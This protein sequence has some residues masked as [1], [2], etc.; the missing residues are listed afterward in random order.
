M[1]KKKSNMIVCVHGIGYDVFA[2]LKWQQFLRIFSLLVLVL[3]AVVLGM[4]LAGRLP[5]EL[6]LTAVLVLILAVLAVLAL[7]RSAIRREYRQS[8]LGKL[9][10]QYEFDR[11]GW[12]V[13]SGGGQVTVPWSKTWRVKRTE[14]ALMLYPSRKSVNLVPRQALTAQQEEQI[15]AW[16]TGKKTG[17]T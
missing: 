14:Q 8:G 6:P 16:C 10:L 7:S 5:K 11:D 12:T 9:E 2:R 3:A 13:K 15:L 4:A 17:K 1:S